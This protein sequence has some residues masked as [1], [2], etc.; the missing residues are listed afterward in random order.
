MTPLLFFSALELVKRIYNK[1]A[2]VG[3]HMHLSVPW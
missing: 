2:L 3:L 1:L